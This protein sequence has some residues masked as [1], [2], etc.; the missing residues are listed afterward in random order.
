MQHDDYYRQMRRRIR[1]WLGTPKGATHRW[2][3]MIFLAPDFLHLLIRLAADPDVPMGL[4]ARLMTAVASFV[5]PLDA[6][7]ELLLGP[8][9][10]VDDVAVA[11]FVV[12]SV[13]NGTGREIVRRHW[14][15]EGD[16]LA[17]VERILA[18][19]DQMLGRGLWTRLRAVFGRPPRR[20]PATR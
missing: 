1:V 15:G 11:A 5:L 8:A 14:A 7:P 17:V 19:A 16:V 2:A 10:Y 20:V 12:H 4:R 3:E 6:I 9:G 13:V 18:V